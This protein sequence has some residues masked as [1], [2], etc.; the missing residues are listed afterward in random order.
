M[1]EKI[2]NTFP[3]N[4]PEKT[5]EKSIETKQAPK[6]ASPLSRLILG[7]GMTITAMG[8]AHAAGKEKTDSSENK[9]V[10]IELY[11]KSNT[12]EGGITPTGKSNSFLDN[13]YG[14]TLDSVM[15]F[16]KQ[17]GL[18][19]DSNLHLQQALFEKYPDIAETL[20]EEYGL[21][22]AHML[23]D[24]LLGI[25]FAETMHLVFLK[26]PPKTPETTSSTPEKK[27][28]VVHITDGYVLNV[29]GDDP[30][31]AY[32]FFKDKN[33]F[34]KFLAAADIPANYGTRGDTWGEITVNMTDAVFRSRCKD[35][36]IEIAGDQIK[37]DPKNYQQFHYVH[38]EHAAALTQSHTIE[39]S[40]E[41][42][43]VN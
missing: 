3:Q 40:S 17:E 41:E 12:P 30:T 42:T 2:F 28:D 25:R 21:P 4:T 18:P 11:T 38:N 22:N 16:A 13:P 32:Y 8:G 31:G 39:A 26:H 43:A 23:E 5:P 24:G 9:K 1:S 14:Y 27:S 6:K 20:L 10:G 7:L 19:T 33:E 35:K 34:E 29:R 37:R 15:A 36:A